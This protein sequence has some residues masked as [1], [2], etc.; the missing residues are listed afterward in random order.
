MEIPLPNGVML[1]SSVGFALQ[2]MVVETAIVV[3]NSVA[4]LL[5]MMGTMPNGIDALIKEPEAYAGFL[6]ALLAV[7]KPGLENK[8][9][10]K[11]LEIVTIWKSDMFGIS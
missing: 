4:W 6:L 11:M 9:A 1:D 5:M 3:T 8:D 7:R 2:A 10:A